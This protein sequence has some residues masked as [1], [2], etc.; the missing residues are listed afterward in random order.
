MT[1]IDTSSLTDSTD[2]TAK[3]TKK[4]AD[5]TEKTNNLFDLVRENLERKAIAEYTANT[6]VQTVDLSGMTNTYYNTNDAFDMVKELGRYLNQ[7]H[8]TSA[9][10]V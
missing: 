4:I 7:K 8:S 9:E 6:K 3:N 1:V 5:N 2:E 10:G